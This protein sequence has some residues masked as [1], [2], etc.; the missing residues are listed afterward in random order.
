MFVE[1]EASVSEGDSAGCSSDEEEGDELEAFEADFIDGA[2][3]PGGTSAKGWVPS[4]F[5]CRM[6]V[7]ST[8]QYLGVQRSFWHQSSYQ[9]TCLK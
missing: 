2:T 8:L 7:R 9:E 1:E 4:P 5:D 6:V 3:Q